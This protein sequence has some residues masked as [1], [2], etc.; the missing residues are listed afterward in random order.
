MRSKGQGC[1]KPLQDIDSQAIPLQY[2]WALVKA[3]AR[4]IRSIILWRTWVLFID[5]ELDVFSYMLVEAH[6]RSKARDACPYAGNAKFPS[7]V[8]NWTS[9]CCSSEI[10]IMQLTRINHVDNYDVVRIVA[11]RIM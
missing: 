9:Q 1:H 2:L 3:N 7:R 4:P 11:T 8:I 6:D 5:L 10:R